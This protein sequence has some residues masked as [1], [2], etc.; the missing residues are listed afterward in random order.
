[1]RDERV[2][3]GME[4]LVLLGWLVVWFALW[5]ARDLGWCGVARRRGRGP[6]RS[7]VGAPRADAVLTPTQ[8]V[9]PGGVP[10]LPEGL[11]RPA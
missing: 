5:A 3:I 1:M 7:A 4:D 6:G 11:G 9:S 8:A 10:T 2:V